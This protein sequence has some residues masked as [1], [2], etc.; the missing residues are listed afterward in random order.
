VDDSCYIFLFTFF[1]WGPTVGGGFLRRSGGR[2]FFFDVRKEGT[3]L[4]HHASLMLAH[5]LSC[6]L[7]PPPPRNTATIPRPPIRRTFAEVIS[8]FPPRLHVPGT[9]TTTNTRVSPCSVVFCTSLHAKA[10]VAVAR[11]EHG[12]KNRRGREGRRREIVST[13]PPRVTCHHGTLTRALRHL[14]VWALLVDETNDSSHNFPFI[15]S[16]EGSSS[17]D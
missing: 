1:I 14:V 2:F 13:V 16:Q 8:A 7:M 3:A 4:A 17:S 6:S 15:S 9:C 11:A 5:T 10:L 12:V